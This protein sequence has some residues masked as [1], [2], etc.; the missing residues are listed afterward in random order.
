MDFILHAFISSRLP[1]KVDM[2]IEKV[3]Q[4]LGD[5]ATVENKEIYWKDNSQ[6]E[7]RFKLPLDTDDAASIIANVIII[8]G[9]FSSAWYILVPSDITNYV[10][11]F[12]GV[13]Y[14]MIKISN[15]VWLSFAIG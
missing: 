7:V 10:E 2:S 13:C 8:I 14:S 4:V 6:T 9:R 1:E 15:V 11:D 5:N 12:S 3:L